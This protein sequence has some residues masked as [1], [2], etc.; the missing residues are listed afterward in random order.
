MDFLD[1]YHPHKYANEMGTG[2]AMEESTDS[3]LT[4]NHT[5][6]TAAM[7]RISNACVFDRHIWTQSMRFV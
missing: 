6:R 5:K 1:N 3:H 2:V 4:M 7:T